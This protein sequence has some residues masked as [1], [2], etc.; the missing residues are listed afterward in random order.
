MGISL[1]EG[2]ALLSLARNRQIGDEIL[3]LGRPELFISERQLKSLAAK[4]ELKW[5]DDEIAHISDSKYG[6]PFLERVGFRTIR[7]LDASEY[8]GAQIIHDLNVPISKE[9]E[10]STRLLFANG[11]IEH[12][13]NVATSLDNITRLLCAGGTAL[14]NGP[15]NG[16]CGHGF[17]QFSPE[18]F[19][20]YFE[21]NGYEDARVYIVG[22]KFPQRW[23]RAIDPRSLNQRVE[24]MT[25]EPAE[26]VAI[27]R[28]VGSLPASV[29]PQQ[30]DY[31]LDLW[32]KADEVRSRKWSPRKKS[33]SSAFYNKVIFP[34]S[35]GLRY[36]AGIG[37]PVLDR[38]PCFEAID[39]FS[40]GV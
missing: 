29:T 39:P 3:C 16:Q 37:M 31:S 18:L 4:M 26:I 13:F 21:A 19:Y 1:I 12:I 17:Y 10:G 22:W 14:I 11:T 20:R 9:L 34:A 24:F 33:I 40:I 28:K 32:N 15:A 5:S 6:E 30:S 35:V 23:F 25:V 8:E 2:V 27:A 38:H 36:L 7:S